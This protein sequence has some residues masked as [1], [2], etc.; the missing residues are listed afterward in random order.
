MGMREYYNNGISFRDNG[1]LDN[2]SEDGVFFDHIPSES[3]LIAAFPNYTDAKTAYQFNV[4]RLDRNSLL[5]DSDINVAADRWA[6]MSTETQTAWATYRQALRD[7][8]A[9]TTDPLNPTWPTRLV[10]PPVAEVIEASPVVEEVIEVTPPVEEV[11]EV[12]P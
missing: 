11:I 6:K 1:E 9:N 4:L 5:R 3:E 10:T 8:P 7:L 2:L 12:T